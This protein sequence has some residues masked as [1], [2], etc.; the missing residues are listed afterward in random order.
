[1]PELNTIGV[2]PGSFDP[3]TF[4]HIELIKTAAKMFSMLYVVVAEN[5]EKKT[6]FTA[7]ERKD[8]IKQCFPD[9]KHLYVHSFDGL[10]ADFCISNNAKYIVRGLRNNVD[11]EKE[12]TMAFINKGIDPSLQTIFIPCDPASIFISSSAVK[13]LVRHHG[14]V[15]K[16]VPEHVARAV[17]EKT[18]ARP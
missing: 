4:G 16:Y 11:F 6:L 7:V 2:Y 13:E 15:S 3:I 14:D 12:L 9:Y 5:Y 8:L 10:I 18:W 17:K 1:M